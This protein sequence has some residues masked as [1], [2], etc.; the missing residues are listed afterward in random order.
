M[1]R[2][3]GFVAFDN[4]AFEAGTVS[5]LH[6]TSSFVAWYCPLQNCSNN[7]VLFYYGIVLDT[8]IA[9]PFHFH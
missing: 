4:D 2:S 5:Q 9:T 8:E 3:Y 7:P 1:A 6:D